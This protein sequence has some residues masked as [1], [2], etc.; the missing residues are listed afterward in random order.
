MRGINCLCRINIIFEQE[1]RGISPQNMLAYQNERRENAICF[2]ASEFE[3]KTG[4]LPSQTIIYKLVAYFEFITLKKSGYLPLG[5]NYRA[6]E[7]GP[8]PLQLYNDREE[9]QSS[10][11]KFIAHSK[12]NPEQRK[13]KALNRPDLDYFSYDETKTMNDLIEIFATSNMSAAIISEASHQSIIAWKKAWQRK[14]NSLIDPSD[15]FEEINIKTED[16]LEP[17]EEHFLT[18]SALEGLGINA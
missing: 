15:T 4:R 17:A 16:E 6:M 7:R 8:V 10:L 11:F 5:Y 14:P 13:V 18:Y 1:Y 9:I 2:F 3:R 12:S